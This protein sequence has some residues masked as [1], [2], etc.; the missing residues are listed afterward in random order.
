VGPG[1]RREKGK[2]NGTSS[3][4]G[5]LGRRLKLGPGQIGSPGPFSH[6]L[7]FSSFSFIFFFFFFCFLISFIDFAF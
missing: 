3:G 5:L 4:L 1:C 7:L 6:F 2:G